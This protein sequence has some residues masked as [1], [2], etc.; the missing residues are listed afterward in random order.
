MPTQITDLLLSSLKIFRTIVDSLE[1]PETGN[2]LGRFF[3]HVNAYSLL[4]TESLSPIQHA[5]LGSLVQVES[6]AYPILK[7]LTKFMPR[8]VLPEYESALPPSDQFRRLATLV[9]FWGLSGRPDEKLSCVQECLDF[10][11]HEIRNETI[12][13]L[14]GCVATLQS[15]Q[16]CPEFRGERRAPRRKRQRPASVWM[17]ART[18]F[19]A[20]AASSKACSPAHNHHYAARLRLATHRKQEDEQYEF[21]TFVTLSLPCHLWQETRIHANLCSTPPKQKVGVKFVTPETNCVNGKYRKRRRLAVERLCEQIE[22]L[23]SKPLMRLNL[24]VEGGKLWKDQSSR[25]EHLINRSEPQL[26]LGDIIR[27]RP[28]SLTEKVK[29]VMAVLLSYSVLH[30]HATPWLQPASF[31][32]DNI[33]FFGTS[34]L[35]PLKPYIHTKLSEGDHFAV[36]NEGDDGV[37]PD[38][39]PSHPF[40]DIVMLAIM[41]MELYIA[42]PV[43]SLADQVGM[44]FDDWDTVDD[45]TRYAIAIAAFDR[46]KGDFPDNYRQAVD[47][48]LDPNIGFD[49]NDEELSEEDLKHLIYDEIV[50]PLEDELDQ[51]FGNTVQ[52][53]R[54]DEIAQTMDLSSWGQMQLAHP[55]RSKSPEPTPPPQDSPKT[56]EGI[57]ASRTATSL[58]TSASEI[59]TTVSCRSHQQYTVGWIC[60]LSTELAAAQALLDEIHPPLPQ[61]ASDRNNYTLGRMGP[62]NVVMACLPAGV[63]GT[64]SAARVANSMLSTFRLLRFGLMVGI[65]GGV[66]GDKDVRLGDVVVGEP[67]GPFGGVI[68]YDFGKTVQN[69]EFRRT[70][71]L[72]R[73]PDLL[74]TAISRLKADHYRK[75]PSLEKHLSEIVDKY[76]DLSARFSHPGAEHDIL[77]ETSRSPHIHYGLIASGNQVMRSGRTR[78]QLRRDLNIICFEME[79][80]GV[81]DVFPCLV[82][83]GICDY[84]DSHKNKGWQGYAAATAAAYAKELLGVISGSQVDNAERLDSFQF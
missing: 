60:A 54:L 4:F 70:G 9:H 76:P 52:I 32:A 56:L 61:D 45:N 31:R 26:S 44:A 69:G 41:L 55:V 47:R 21:D 46:F 53:D 36:H 28:A 14:R 58:S 80:A 2:E 16:A 3:G 12:L 40:P 1:E 81:V 24:A 33:L 34:T 67:A 39:L 50:Q 37:D 68:Q 74:L 77:F 6:L 83:R 62:H 79:A 35:I 38:D 15:Y 10:T 57:Y 71:S 82:I 42:R 23:Q 29:R 75:R 51:G 17:G 25:C 63:I 72:N 43:Q 78:E 13:L 18:V 59:F 27:C 19:Q 8:S 49:Q 11:C 48:C 22:K 64:V 7:K 65:G 66:P 20:L 73:P 5:P 84:S 30:L